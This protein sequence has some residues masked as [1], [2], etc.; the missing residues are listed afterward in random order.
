MEIGLPS[1]PLCIPLS[2]RESTGLSRIYVDRSPDSGGAGSTSSSGLDIPTLASRIDGSP[3][4]G[5][6]SVFIAEFR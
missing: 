4:L 1:S 3:A 5:P 2:E 6:P